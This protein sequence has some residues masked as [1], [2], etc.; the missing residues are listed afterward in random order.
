[1]FCVLCLVSQSCLTLR[2][3][4]DCSPLSLG[5]LQA[6]ILEWVACPPP[7]NLRK[8]GIKPRSPTLQ[9]DSLPSQPSG[10][11]QNTGVGS[12]SLLQESFLT[13]EWNQGLLCCRQI[14]YPLSYQGSPSFALY[15]KSQSS[16]PGASLVAQRVKNLPVMQET[17][18]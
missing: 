18:V 14:L 3:P 10:K 13:Q 11:P 8:A 4:M 16:L 1:M 7:G 17:W 6:R 2:D 15:T 9:A 5:I 12:L